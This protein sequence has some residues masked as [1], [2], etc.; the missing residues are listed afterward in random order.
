MAKKF[1]LGCV[2]V[3]VLK[4]LGL[5]VSYGLGHPC[6]T[7]DFKHCMRER[8]RERVWERDRCSC[9]YLV[10][11]PLVNHVCMIST[12][13]LILPIRVCVF[14]EITCPRCFFRGGLI[15]D[16]SARF[17]WQTSL[18]RDMSTFPSYLVLDCALAMDSYN[19][20]LQALRER[21]RDVVAYTLP[22][23]RFWITFVCDIDC[24]VDKGGLWTSVSAVLLDII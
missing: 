15:E 5:L 23:V 2:R 10:Y 14:I 16:R 12:V 11:C 18:F 20:L 19:T 24:F 3:S 1:V 9:L 6:T 4:R 21:A 13:S 7:P 17:G 8:V 22:M